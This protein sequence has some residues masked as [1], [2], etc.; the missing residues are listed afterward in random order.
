M[1]EVATNLEVLLSVVDHSK[2]VDRA[3]TL[4]P[5]R[6]K[7]VLFSRDIVEISSRETSEEAAD[8]SSNKVSVVLAFKG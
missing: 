1:D 4:F 8:S 2:V 7:E 3:E 6:D 5:D